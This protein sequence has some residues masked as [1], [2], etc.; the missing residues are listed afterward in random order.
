MEHIKW[1]DLEITDG[2]MNAEIKKK[3]IYIFKCWKSSRILAT[4][5]QKVH[6]WRPK[7]NI[8]LITTTDD[9]LELFQ[10]LEKKDEDISNFTVEILFENESVLRVQMI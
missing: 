6:R 7:H 3:A 2:T 9:L 4:E 1:F 10:L 5:G 8:A